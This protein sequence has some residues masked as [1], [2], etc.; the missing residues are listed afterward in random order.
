VFTLMNPLV[1]VLWGILVFGQHPR[2]GAWIV[3]EVAGAAVVVAATL[4]LTRSPALVGGSGPEPADGP[5]AERHRD[6]VVQ[7]S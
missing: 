7:R 1:G 5:Q 2:G 6:R 3:G 4:L